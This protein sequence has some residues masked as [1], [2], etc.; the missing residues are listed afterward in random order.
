M[1]ALENIKNSLIDRIL[2]TQNERL[3]QAISTIFETSASEETVGLSSEQIE[4][5]A[6]SDDDIVNGRVIS[7]EDL[8]A[9]DP[10][11]LQ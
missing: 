10:E 2:A 4:M 9:S 8:K 5:L 7:E 6:M 3:L 11:W 1:T